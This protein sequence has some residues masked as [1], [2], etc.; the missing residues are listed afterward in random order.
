MLLRCFRYAID[1]AIDTRPADVIRH[2]A[3]Y[4]R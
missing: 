3:G 4:Y 2:D 1:G